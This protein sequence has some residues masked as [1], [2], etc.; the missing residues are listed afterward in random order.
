MHIAGADGRTCEQP[1][2][3]SSSSRLT[4][5]QVVDRIIKIN[6]TATEAFLSR[7]SDDSLGEYLDHL[8][9]ASGPRG[10]ESRWLRRADSPAILARESED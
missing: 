1:E 4:R 10:P 9:M 7:F 5:E 2:C 3:S 6:P 8:V